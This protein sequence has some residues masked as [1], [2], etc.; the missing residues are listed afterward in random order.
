MPRTFP[1]L[2]LL[3]LIGPPSSE[4]LNR[5]VH[6]FA[7]SKLGETVGDGE[8]SALVVAAY[9]HAGAKRPRRGEEWGTPVGTLDAVKPGDVLQ[10]DDAEFRGR[11]VRGQ[12]IRTW[13]YRFPQ[14]TAIVSD[15]TTRRRA[16]WLRILH[17]N[18]IIPDQDESP[19]VKEW[20]LNMTEL[21]SGDV[22]A[23]RPI[24]AEPE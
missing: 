17:Q 9:K 13:T 12:T 10:F 5:D 21:R 7:R 14:H 4:S 20:A 3:A 2:L 18:A 16:L 22:R 19:A 15:V 23:F 11:I 8:C 1:I 24:P 6:T